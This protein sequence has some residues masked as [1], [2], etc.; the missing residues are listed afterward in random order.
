MPVR[1]TVM[2]SST[3]RDLPVHR[4]AAMDAC[5]GLGLFPRMME[6]L[7]ARD[8]DAIAASLAMVDQANVYLGVFAHRYGY[9]PAG[10]SI[11]VTEMEYNRAVERGIPCLLFF[12][13][14]DHPV[15]AADVETGDGAT[16][17]QALRGRLL[18]ERV[19]NFFRSPDDLRAQIIQSLSEY[20][21]PDRSEPPAPWKVPPFN[22]NLFIGRETIL[23]RLHEELGRS[24]RAVLHGLPGVGKT[25]TAIAYAHR[26]RSDY[27]G[28]LWVN[29]DTRDTLNADF[30]AIARLLGLSL[31]EEREAQVIVAAVMGELQR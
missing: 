22:P 8:D 11:S 18:Q 10:H 9:V 20:R 21:N 28:I 1:I 17:L 14:E 26:H 5:L 3:A 31:Q 2:I 6:H 30:A 29:A 16:R 13:H 19:V 23:Q 12:M 24:R 15:R 4:Q 7:P 27:Q 25:L